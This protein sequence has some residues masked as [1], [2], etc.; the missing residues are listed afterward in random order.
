L[1]ADILLG[2]QGWSYPDWVGPFYPPGTRQ[3]DF[4]T[5]YS[6]VFPTVELDTTFY[7]LPRPATVEGWRRRTPDGFEFTA[8]LPQR[9]THEKRL[10]DVKDELFEFLAVMKLLGEKLGPLLVQLPPDFRNGPAELQQVDDFVKLLP[11]NQLFA[12]EFRH[13]SWA[14]EE[15]FAILSE[16][17]ICWCIND[18]PYLPKRVEVTGDFSYLRWLGDHRQI[19]SFAATQIDRSADYDAW[20]ATLRE[21]SSRVTR[22]YGYFNNHYAGHSPA[23]VRQLQRRLGQ[24]ESAPPA[25]GLFD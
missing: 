10:V 18:L 5:L 3:A 16:R 8:K 1:S 22:V 4:L 15:V 21:L 20:A 19:A 23:S 11:P 25:R 12:I 2:T 7:G 14:Q 6:Q 9:I 24:P 17:R 13:R